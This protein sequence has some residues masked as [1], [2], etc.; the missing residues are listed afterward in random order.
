MIPKI[1]N[2]LTAVEK[3]VKQVRITSADSLGS[4]NSGTV[5]MI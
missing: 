2:A 1:E 4:P 3:G 5:V